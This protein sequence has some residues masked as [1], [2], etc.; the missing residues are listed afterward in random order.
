MREKSIQIGKST[1]LLLWI[2][3]KII[4]GFF[5]IFLLAFG[6]AITFLWLAKSNFG[7]LLLAFVVTGVLVVLMS[8]KNQ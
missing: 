5:G 6:G 4:S 8:T 2:L 3:I 1:I 7:S